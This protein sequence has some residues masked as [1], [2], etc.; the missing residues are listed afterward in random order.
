MTNAG[1][2]SEPP[3]GFGRRHPTAALLL[4]SAVG[5]F[6]ELMLIRWIGTEVRIFAYLQNTVLV[7]CFLGLGMGCFTCRQSARVGQALIPLLILILLLAFPWTRGPIDRISESLAVFGDV[8]IWEM[9]DDG[10][11]ASRSVRLVIAGGLTFLLMALIWEVFVPIGRILGRLMDDHPRI[12]WAYSV[13]VLGS[14]FGIWLFALLSSLYQ[15]PIVWVVAMGVLMLPFI[16]REQSRSFSFLLLAL[17]IASAWLVDRAPDARFVRWSPYQKLALYELPGD[18][19]AVGK[20]I[21]NVNNAGYQG[22]LDLRPE[23]IRGN[24]KRYDP[25]QAGYS[26]YDVPMLLHPAPK[27]VL[28]V[29]SGTGNDVAGALRHNVEHV[30]A[31]EI[32]PAIISIGR[33]LHPEQP[34]SSPKVTVVNDD[35]RSYFAT[36]RERYDIVIF[37]LLD[38]H[39]TT[40]MTNARLDHY[41][42]TIESIRHA[43]G[44]LKDGG[45]MVLSFEAQKPYIVDRMARTLAEAFG[46]EPIAFRIPINHYGWGGVLFVAGNLTE[47]RKR[48]ASDPKLAANI[49]RWRRDYPISIG[50]AAQPSTD[51]WPYLY[52]PAPSIPSL[53][54]LLALETALLVVY[55]RF[56]LRQ[57]VFGAHWSTSHW[58]FFF[59]GAA[60]LLLEVQN[61]SKASV[62]LGNTWQVSGVVISAVL[63]MIL[64]ANAAAA[65]WPRLP[66]AAVY[67]GLIAT[68]LA[69]YFVDLSRFAFLAFPVK[70]ALVGL[71]TTLPIFFSGI[72]FIRSFA[73]TPAKDEALGANLIG[74]LVG[75]LLQSITFWIGI[76]ALLLVVAGLYLM[77]LASRPRETGAKPF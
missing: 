34:Y 60:F 53:Y 69:L 37:G 41:V 11:S 1:I 50:S 66:I 73:A 59:L 35:A 6:V 71:L 75:G 16:V 10:T 48:I 76:K 74:G 2:E 22:M 24:P 5:L 44:L 62:A 42:Y 14:L 40:A 52:L 64:L 61:I 51:D 46:A 72:V 32:D 23:S 28:I 3:E 36:A 31:V 27:S 39:T 18:S 13:N 43:R 17:T 8:L 4:I 65:A 68:C 67:F 58:H 49:D 9:P 20:Y 77:A 26:Q 15:P 55:A 38:S 70:A 19:E 25:E 21:V 54:L 30:T 47:V 56:R 63:I 57:P 7:V 33:Q 45:V 29:G 12:I